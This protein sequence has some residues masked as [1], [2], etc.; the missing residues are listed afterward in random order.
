VQPVPTD[1]DPQLTAR[2][3]YRRLAK[4]SAGPLFSRLG[5]I[6]LEVDPGTKWLAPAHSILDRSADDWNER[7]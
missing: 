2:D 7:P 4:H 1:V 6:L 3:L 5:T